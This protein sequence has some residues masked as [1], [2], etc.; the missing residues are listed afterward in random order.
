M[1][2]VGKY[3]SAIV[4]QARS[5]IGLNEADGTHKK[6]I[7]LYNEH[8]PLAR[9]YRVKYTDAWCAT[10]GSALAIVLGYTDII[11]TEC[12]CGNQI[13]LWKKMGCWVEDDSHVPE[14]GEYIYYDWDDSGVGDNKGWPDHVGVVEKV[15]NGVITVIE[16]NYSNAVKR[17]TIKVNAKNI[18]G[19]GVPKYDTE[20]EV[21]SKPTA[22]AENTPVKTEHST[23]NTTSNKQGVCKVDIKVLRKGEKGSDVRALQTLLT[24]YGYSCGTHGVDGS[25]GSATEKAV[26]KYQKAKGL[27]TD[28][29]VGPK[30]WSKL[31]GV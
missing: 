4:N 1:M 3:A 16:G 30:T 2:N 19:Y 8:K 13:E 17:R 15:V 11:P 12:G 14:P 26:K 20:P 18:R 23:T 10:F 29:V 9:N 7:D 31:L 27:E 21:K 5:W 24:G 6:I 25:F 22:N 28:G